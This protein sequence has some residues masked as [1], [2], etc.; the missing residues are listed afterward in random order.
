MEIV[1]SLS[2]IS[3]RNKVDDGSEA[4]AGVVGLLIDR[5]QFWLVRRY[6]LGHTP[7]AREDT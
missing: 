5:Y 2:V 1:S 4:V 3:I 7:L 6:G